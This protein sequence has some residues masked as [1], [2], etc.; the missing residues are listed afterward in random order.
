MKYRGKSPSEKFVSAVVGFI[1]GTHLHHKP[2][3]S[4]FSLFH[5]SRQVRRQI[6]ELERLCDETLKSK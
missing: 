1:A 6:K 3:P 2:R 4:T 5:E